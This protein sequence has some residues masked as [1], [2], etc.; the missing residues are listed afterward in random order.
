MSNL[1]E[2]CQHRQFSPVCQLIVLADVYRQPE[3]AIIYGDSL[4]EISDYRNTV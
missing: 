2:G 1:P 3:A 4:L